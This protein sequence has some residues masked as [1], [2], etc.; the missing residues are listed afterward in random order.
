MRALALLLLCACE[1]APTDPGTG[2]LMRVSGAQFY[3]GVMPAAQDGPPV[4]TADIS[5]TQV[6]AGSIDRTVSGSLDPAATA[7]AVGLAGDSG[8]WIITAGPMNVQE[9]GYPTFKGSLGFSSLLPAG[10]YQLI[11]RA[12]DRAGRFGPPHSITL[13]A[14]GPVLPDGMLVVTLRWDTESDLDLHVVD[15]SGAIIWA[16]DINSYMMPPPGTV[17]DPNAWKAGGILDFDSNAQCAIDGR[18]REDVIWTMPPPS[19]HYLVR[20][21]AF[22]M[23]GQLFAHWSVD[24]RLAGELVAHA[25]GSMFDADTRGMHGRDAGLDALAFDVP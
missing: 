24:V 1:A 14:S 2:S 25:S 20:V 5:R 4:K 3:P 7:A 21:D 22:S 23:C 18:L 19:G 10:D 8:Y 12:V 15:P 6:E 11:V 9:P 13:Q 16:G 17:P